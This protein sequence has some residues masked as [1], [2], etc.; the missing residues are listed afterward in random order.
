[1]ESLSL[2]W[3]FRPQMTI[4]TRRRPTNTGGT[5]LKQNLTLMF[6]VF[7]SDLGTQEVAVFGRTSEGNGTQYA[8]PTS[9]LQNHVTHFFMYIDTISRFHTI[10]VKLATQKLVLC[11]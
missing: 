9:Q 11:L 4:P 5:I 8:A 2:Q 7:L 10:S 3:T 1:M 6:H